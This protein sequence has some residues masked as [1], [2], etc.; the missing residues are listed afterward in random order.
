MDPGQNQIIERR[1]SPASGA[2][3]HW[4]AVPAHATWKEL[5]SKK[6]SPPPENQNENLRDIG[7]KIGA[8]GFYIAVPGDNEH[9][10][11]AYD[12]NPKKRNS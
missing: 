7:P 5:R 8:W 12:S 9:K 1:R 6:S 4:S 2:P 11:Q 3:N 10:Y